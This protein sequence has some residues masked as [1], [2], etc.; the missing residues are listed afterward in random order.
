LS[1]SVLF[2]NAQPAEIISIR[3][4]NTTQLSLVYVFYYIIAAATFTQLAQHAKLVPCFL[5]R[6]LEMNHTPPEDAGV[7]IV[8]YILY[9]VCIAAHDA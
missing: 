2:T 5:L 7:D 8:I 9:I 4:T 6:G 3:R 1:F